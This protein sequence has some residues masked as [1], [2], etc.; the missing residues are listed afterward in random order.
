M[1]VYTVSLTRV[2]ISTVVRT[3][4]Q[5]AAGANPLEILKIRLGQTTGTSLDKQPVELCRKTAAATVTPFTPIKN[6]PTG[7]PAS[8]AIGGA[9]LTGTDASVEGTNGDILAQGVFNYVNEWLWFPVRDEKIW[10]PPSGIVGFR[11]PI[12]PGGAV[13]CTCDITFKEHNGC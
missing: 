12:A 1:S 7:Q 4:I 9:A 11:F 13:I 3:L 10:I 5:I 2:S 6:G 8:L